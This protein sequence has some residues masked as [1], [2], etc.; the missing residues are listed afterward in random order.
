M[1]LPVASIITPATL[2]VEMAPFSNSTLVRVPR[3]D[4]TSINF[5]NLDPFFARASDVNTFYNVYKGPMPGVQRIVDSTAM[6]GAIL[7]IEPPSTNFRCFPQCVGTSNKWQ[8]NGHVTPN[9]GCHGVTVYT[10]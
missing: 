1:L 2:N 10:V 5:V 6:E 9:A 3:V 4:F 7:P 8:S